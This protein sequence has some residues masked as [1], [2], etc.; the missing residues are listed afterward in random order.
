MLRIGGVDSTLVNGDCT[1]ERDKYMSHN[2]TNMFEGD[3]VIIYVRGCD[4]LKL[5]VLFCP[6]GHLIE[7]GLVWRIY[8]LLGLAACVCVGT[9]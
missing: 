2:L 3:S 1:S 8:R 7:L 6:E 5:W 9:T 4:S